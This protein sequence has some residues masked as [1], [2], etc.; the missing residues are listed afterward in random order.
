MVL[1]ITLVSLLGHFGR[2]LGSLWGHFGIIFGSLSIWLGSLWSY[3]QKLRLEHTILLGKIVKYFD[4]AL[5][6]LCF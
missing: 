6:A 1:D 5:R 4:A 3:L 2:T